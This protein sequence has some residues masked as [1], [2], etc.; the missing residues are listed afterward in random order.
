MVKGKCPSTQKHNTCPLCRE[1]YRRLIH[2]GKPIDV[3]APV[4]P[5]RAERSVLPPHDS[6]VRR[7]VLLPASYSQPMNLAF[8]MFQPPLFEFNRFVVPAQPLFQARS[9]QFLPSYPF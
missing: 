5:Q 1:K 8:S 3:A 7:M 9:F 2:K 4:L 6:N